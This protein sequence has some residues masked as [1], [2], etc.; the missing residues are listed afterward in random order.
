[1]ASILE[2][3][4]YFLTQHNQLTGKATKAVSRKLAQDVRKRTRPRQWKGRAKPARVAHQDARHHLVSQ[5]AINL[6]AGSETISAGDDP[7]RW[8]PGSSKSS[9]RP[10]NRINKRIASPLVVV[11]R[12]YKNIVTTENKLTR[13]QTKQK[14][15]TKLCPYSFRP[16]F[17]FH[18][19]FAAANGNKDL[20]QLPSNLTL[21]N[22][23]R[24]HIS[25]DS[26]ANNS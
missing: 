1:M 14:Q 6:R 23:D 15:T 2:A 7:T 17:T 3:T 22:R 4:I 19:R 24:S 12:E 5:L 13:I 9:G 25:W 26:Q 8:K 11:K 16:F 20:Q 21:C 10:S 18:S